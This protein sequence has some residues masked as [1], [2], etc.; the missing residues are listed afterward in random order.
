MFFPI[1]ALTLGAILVAVVVN[2]IVFSPA[3]VGGMLLY[4]AIVGTPG[5]PGLAAH[6]RARLEA[7][8]ARRSMDSL[9][10]AA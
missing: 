8:K 6:V 1:K 10:R 7:R 3:I 4:R 2:L 5:H 9:D